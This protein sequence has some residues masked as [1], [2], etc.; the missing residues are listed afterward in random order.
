MGLTK[1]QREYVD[2]LR[3]HGETDQATLM[4]HF[5][6]EARTASGVLNRLLEAG[7]V[8][9]RFGMVEDRDGR[10]DDERDVLWRLP[11]QREGRRRSRPIRNIMMRRED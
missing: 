9:L 7:E 2:Y 5:K 11:G 1:R 8:K 6:V 4:G 3:E 10:W